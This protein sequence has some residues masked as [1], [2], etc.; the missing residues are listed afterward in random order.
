M[1]E[2]RVFAQCLMVGGQQGASRLGFLALGS[3]RGAGDQR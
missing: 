2:A 1:C 3:V